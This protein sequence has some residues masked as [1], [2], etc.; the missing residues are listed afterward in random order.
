LCVTGYNLYGSLGTGD[1]TNVVGFDKKCYPRPGPCYANN[2][3]CKRTCINN[4]GTVTCGECPAGYVNDGEKGCKDEDECAS[5][6][7]GC[8]SKR[9]C[10]NTVGSFKCEDCPC[11]YVND[12]AK[13][14][15]ASVPFTV[16]LQKPATGACPSGTALTEAEC[17]CLHG[18]TAGGKSVH[19]IQAKV[20][21][22]PEQCGCYFDQDGKVYFNPRT[23]DCTQT[24]PGEI[25]ICKGS[26]G[27]RV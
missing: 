12:G 15:K 5:N 10:T 26:G 2:G 6:N 14:C 9:K 22:N 11:G 20:Y 21:A 16:Q 13:G 23:T 7:G 8:D 17:A 4:K 18:K 19:Y 3:G 1:K 27:G 25:G 24:D